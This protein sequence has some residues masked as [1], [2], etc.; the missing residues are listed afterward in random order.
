M[1]VSFVRSYMRGGRRKAAFILIIPPLF[2]L[3][4][5]RIK[6]S[7]QEERERGGERRMSPVLLSDGRSRA[8]G[9]AKGESMCIG[10]QEGKK[11]ASDL[12]LADVENG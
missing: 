6:K 5:S 1:D 2:S 10:Q 9:Q 3:L 11:C 8:G 7:K 12:V 4:E